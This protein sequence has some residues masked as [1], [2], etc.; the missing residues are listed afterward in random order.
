MRRRRKGNCTIGLHKS[1]QLFLGNAPQALMPRGANHLTER[2]SLD[3][4]VYPNGTYL[5]VYYQ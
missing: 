5:M 1:L 3:I 4:Q 2:P